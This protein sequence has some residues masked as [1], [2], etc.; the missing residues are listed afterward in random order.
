MS[1][2]QKT[3]S[4]NPIFRTIGR[5]EQFLDDF[6]ERVGDAFVVGIRDGARSAYQRLLQPK[7]K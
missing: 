7:E 3:S 1:Q 6:T 4:T 5:A 2:H